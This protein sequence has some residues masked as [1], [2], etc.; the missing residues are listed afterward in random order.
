MFAGEGYAAHWQHGSPRPVPRGNVSMAWDS[1]ETGPIS[2]RHHGDTTGTA[3]LV[4]EGSL[5]WGWVK[6]KYQQDTYHFWPRR[7]C[8]LQHSR[9]F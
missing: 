2:T 7:C 1:V 3:P 5:F 6:G 9:R 4:F 8:W